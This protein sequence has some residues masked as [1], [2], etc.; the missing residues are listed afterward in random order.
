MYCSFLGMGLGAVGKGIWG[1]EVNNS[2]HCLVLFVTVLFIR[3]E[4]LSLF[5]LLKTSLSGQFCSKVLLK[6]Y[7][8]TLQ[9]WDFDG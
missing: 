9:W 4:C 3:E 8:N 5:T 6:I 1:P 7:T 2:E